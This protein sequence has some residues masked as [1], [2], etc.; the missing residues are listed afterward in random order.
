M[1]GGLSDA[2]RARLA[3]V[4]TASITTVLFKRGLRNTFM[5]GPTLAN[6]DA[7]RMVGE[8]YTMRYIPA[9]EDLDHLAVFED[10]SHPQRKGVEECPAGHVFVIDSRGD[11]RAASAGGILITRLMVRGAAGIVTDGGFRD[12]GDLAGMDFPVYQAGPSAP[13]NLIH[14]HAGVIAHL[15]LE[16]RSSLH[17]NSEVGVFTHLNE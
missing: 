8:A 5:Q 15:V 12:G 7:P 14:H 4:S 9:R 11:R 1:G 3:Q 13:T 6:P 2:G 10:R 16:L 17:S